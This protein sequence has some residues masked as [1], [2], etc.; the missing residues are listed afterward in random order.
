MITS[1]K[2]IA[3]GARI[4][5]DSLGAE[6]AR[7]VT[8]R[9]EWKGNLKLLAAAPGLLAELDSAHEWMLLEGHQCGEDCSIVLSLRE[10]GR[11]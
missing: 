11:R 2:W 7:V 3:D 8:H 10:A 1:G 4:I 6:I 9:K 5:D